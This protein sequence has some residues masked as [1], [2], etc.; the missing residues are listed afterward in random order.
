MG[1]GA[2]SSAAAASP[3]SH[4][5][6]PW[7]AGVGGEGGDD[8]KAGKLAALREQEN[9]LQAMAA[10]VAGMKGSSA[11]ERK[12][13]LEKE[14]FDIRASITEL[15][16]PK[17]R[18][19]SLAV[20]VQT[21]EKRL[22]AV[23]TRQCNATAAPQAAVDELEAVNT[24]HADALLDLE[25]TRAKLAAA[26]LVAAEHDGAVLAH[27]DPLVSAIRAVEALA[28]TPMLAELLP[29]QMV[30]AVLATLQ[31]AAL[32]A[33]RGS[34]AVRS[35]D[36]MECDI[37]VQDPYGA[38]H[39]D[40]R[41]GGLLDGGGVA[42]YAPSSPEAAAFAVVLIE[43]DISGGGAPFGLSELELKAQQMLAA[44]S[45]LPGGSSMDFDLTAEDYGA[46]VD[47]ETLVRELPPIKRQQVVRGTNTSVF[48]LADTGQPPI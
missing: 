5:A 22:K 23:E 14:L 37:S 48:Q 2:A 1:K 47:D 28:S 31:A 33:R 34:V 7:T 4:V 39:G 45:Q 3:P 44:C 32:K 19:K 17:D 38:A 15:K 13:Q 18:V 26:E 42:H 8:D 35:S 43:D 29:P 12:A 27:R 25:S 21:R 11:A 36:D 9:M 6:S 30:Q 10:S 41:G 16:C 20:A 40:M 24:E 46:S